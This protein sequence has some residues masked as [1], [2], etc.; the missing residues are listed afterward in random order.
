MARWASLVEQRRAERPTLLVDAGDFH[1]S[2]PLVY[3]DVRDRYF[4]DGMRYM[5][6][7]AVGIGEYETAARTENFLES[8][9]R[10]RLPFLSTNIVSAATRKPIAEQEIVKTFGGRRTMFGR[11]GGWRVGMFS[12]ASP[13]LVYG[14]G[15]N[16]AARYYV[17]DPKIAAVEAV[18]KLRREGCS[19][20]VAISHQPWE[21]SIDLARAVPGIDV[22]VGSH[23]THGMTYGELVGK[24]L[25]VDPGPVGASFAEIE[26][27]FA[28]MGPTLGATERCHEIITTPGDP[29]LVA[30]D[31]KYQ[32]EIHSFPTAGLK[33]DS[34]TVKDTTKGRGD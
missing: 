2:H 28:A 8:L 9:K 15:D 32:K 1:W 14:F 20:I 31:R 5:R 29:W 23:T 21:K 27:T 7:D 25:V 18:A 10:Y 3:Q 11:T 26:V 19:V 30:L 16:A 22:V 4:F 6:Y 24:T 17:V 12:V 34:L 13:E 33:L